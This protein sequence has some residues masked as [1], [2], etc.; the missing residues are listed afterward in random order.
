MKKLSILFVLIFAAFTISR[1]Q[2]MVN[3]TFQVDMSYYDNPNDVQVVIKNPWIWTALTDDGNGIWSGTVEVDANSTY[4]YTFVNGG[5]DNWGEEESVPEEC[6]FG[7]QSAPERHVEVGTEDLVVELVA[8]GSCDENPPEEK[9]NVTLQVDLNN[10]SDLYD[11]D[12]VWVYMDA[13]WS[14]YYTMTDEDEDGVYAYTLERDAGSTLS[15]RF[16]YQYGADPEW[17]YTEE[18]VPAACANADE[19]REVM[20]PYH[21]IS[22]GPDV[23]EECVGDSVNVTFQLDLNH[24]TDLYD[25]GAGW[26]YMDWNWVE[27]YVM[28]DDDEDGVYTLT[29]KREAGSVLTYSFSY[30]NGPDDWSDFA[31]E[32]LPNQ[33]ANGDGF[34][35]YTIPNTHATLPVFAFSSCDENPIPRANITF[36]VDMSL[37]TNPNDVQVVIKDPWIWTALTDQGNGIWSGTV[38]VN[39]YDTYPYTYVNGGQDNWDEEESVP[40]ECNFGTESA[41][42]R[43]VTVE[44]E[45][46]LLEVVSFGSCIHITSVESHQIPGFKLYPNPAGEY[47]NIS[48]GD[49]TIRSLQILNINGKVLETHVF[50]R[51]PEARVNVQHINSGVYLIKIQGQSA[52]VNSKLVIN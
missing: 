51:S 16:S 39:G 30:Q 15:Y 18:A 17:D 34:R 10:V 19:F 2:D 35:E 37:E 21:D 9:I 48:M 38:E 13:D 52:T 43:H 1:A 28:T 24:V 41:P 14:E 25:G 40:M 8:F 47:L 49:E 26:V 31:V 22:F 23:Y 36:Q 32:N 12:G 46:L 44:D 5:Q 20:V 3:I 27:S 7:S 33:C 29:L 4:P 45:D 6:N 11:E 42:E 50:G